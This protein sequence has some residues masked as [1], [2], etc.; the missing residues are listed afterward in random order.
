MNE[1]N[2]ITIKQDIVYHI[3]RQIAKMSALFNIKTLNYSYEKRI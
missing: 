1:L 3:N 2:Q